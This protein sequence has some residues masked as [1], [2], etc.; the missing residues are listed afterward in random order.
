MSKDILPEL[1]RVKIT[2]QEVE[3]GWVIQEEQR[4][5]RSCRDRVRKAKADLEYCNPF[6]AS[7]SMKRKAQG[8]KDE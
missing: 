4:V 1:K 2:V 5:M 3:V 8:H 6:L 7:W